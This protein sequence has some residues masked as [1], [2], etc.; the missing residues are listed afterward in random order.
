MP[1][2]LMLWPGNPALSAL[3][4]FVA[5]VLVLY[6][7]RQ[8]AHRGI[9]GIARAVSQ[10]CTLT[11][12]AL[13]GVQE[14][15]GE[16]TRE[17][18]LSEGLDDAERQIQQEFRRISDA[19]ERDMGA[20]PVLHR[21]LSDQVTRIDEDYRRVTDS[22]PEPEAWSQTILAAGELVEKA[23]NQTAAA[24][25]VDALRVT[26]EDAHDDAMES[27]RET[28]RERHELLAKMVPA[29][30]SMA[31]TLD[32][33]EK[34]VA[35]IFE[36]SEH[37]DD[38]MS[39][40]REIAAKSDVAERKLTSSTLTQFAIASLVLV[41]ASLGG[42]INFQLIAL[43]MSEMVGA[44]SRLGSMQTSDVAA[45]VIILVEITMGLFLM[46]SL[47]VTRLFPVIGRLDARAR[48]RMAIATFSILFIL[49]GIE[50]SLA[51]M[52]DMLAADRMA[53][54]QQLAGAAT[55]RPEFMW[56]P[57]VGQMVMG[58]ILPFALTFVAIPLESFIHSGR[59]VLGQV[60]AGLLRL[61]AFGVQM[62]G[63]AAEHLGTG[64]ENLY[65]VIV[66]L[67]LKVEELVFRARAEQ[68]PNGGS[69]VGADR[70]TST[71]TA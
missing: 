54:T 33:V 4:L 12:E 38:L 17:V 65:D 71:S 8:P 22:P 68:A 66:F 5:I 63:F 47:R 62:I 67:P 52:R 55:Q 53:L 51:Y 1:T 36:R 37:L 48:R 64:L 26:I 42:F 3:L 60:T 28:S 70:S 43:P 6:G 30:R 7:A 10:G 31:A 2:W 20:Y 69:D 15:M 49:A 57:A 45:L 61:L 9:R 29:W 59:I 56:I 24:K 27:Y 11:A 46:E 34:A 18:L 44:T 40:Y 35:N 58:F 16:R 19:V 25:A 32:R 50:A 39:A 21:K 41:V 13:R 23:G 14:R